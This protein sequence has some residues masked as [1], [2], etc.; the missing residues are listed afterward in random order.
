MEQSF[1]A[2]TQA[3]YS[4]LKR[5][6]ADYIKALSIITEL[7][8]LDLSSGKWRVAEDMSGILM[9]GETSGTDKPVEQPAKPGQP[10]GKN[11]TKR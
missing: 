4:V 5:L 2:F 8:G 3:E 6:H 9:E 10:T 7:R 1:I 11:P